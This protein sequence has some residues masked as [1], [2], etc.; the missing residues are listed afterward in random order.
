MPP[1]SSGTVQQS[2]PSAPALSQSSRG[3]MPSSS[4]LRVER[5]DL[6]IDEAPDRF[7][8]NVMFFS[9]HGSLDHGRNGILLF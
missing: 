2:R 3:T 4:H 6:A 5:H 8:E 1:Y 7:P 9:E